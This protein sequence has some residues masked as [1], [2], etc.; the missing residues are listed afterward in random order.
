MRCFQGCCFYNVQNRCAAPRYTVECSD[1]ISE[2]DAVRSTRL[3]AGA[4]RPTT[5]GACPVARCRGAKRPGN[6]EFSGAS[7]AVTICSEVRP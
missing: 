7:S 6:N 1:R 2:P 3:L 5:N 4:K